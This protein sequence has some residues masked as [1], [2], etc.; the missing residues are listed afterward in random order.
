MTTLK[1][2]LLFYALLAIFVAGGLFFKDK[3]YDY[4]LLG[5]FIGLMGLEMIDYV[6][7]TTVLL[8]ISAFFFARYYFFV[9]FLYGPILWFYVHFSIRGKQQFY[10]PDAWHLLPLVLAFLYFFDIYILPGE[11]RLMY[12]RAHFSDRIMPLNYARA[13][14]LLV[15]SLG[16]VRFCWKMPAATSRIKKTVTIAIV[17]IYCFT[18][19]LMAWFTHF[20]QGW[21]DFVPY[22]LIIATIVFMM[23]YLLYFHPNFLTQLGAKY[24]HSSISE[25]QMI[26]IQGKITASMQEEKLFLERGLNLKRLA[27]KIDEKPHHISQT[28][29]LLLHESF[30]DHVN[31]YR[32]EF[33]KCLLTDPTSQQ[34][35]IEAIALDAGFNNKVTFNKFFQKFTGMKPSTFKNTHPVSSRK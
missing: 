33:A 6:Y 19:F 21:N 9:G 26:Q 23:A 25:E 17:S 12:M 1:T 13:L 31:R 34:Y 18:S 5:L 15:Y 4:K 22:Y 35:T 3:G 8:D 24:M 32:I 29:T 28:F 14:H 27:Q 16:L 20:A 7:S 2:I 11:D 30:N 10:R